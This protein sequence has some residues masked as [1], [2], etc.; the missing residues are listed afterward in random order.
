MVPKNIIQKK[1]KTNSNTIYINNFKMHVGDK[2][3]YCMFSIYIQS[4]S[5]IKKAYDIKN[6]VDV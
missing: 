5:N 2:T 4:P 6:I 1:E 3:A